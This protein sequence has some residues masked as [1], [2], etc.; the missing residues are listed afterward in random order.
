[1][2]VLREL[3]LYEVLSKSTVLYPRLWWSFAND[4]GKLIALA[5]GDGMK[6][7]N[8]DSEKVERDT[9]RQTA[10]AQSSSG[11]EDVVKELDVVCPFRVRARDSFAHLALRPA[12][13]KVG[14]G[15][16]SEATHVVT[17]QCNGFDLVSRCH[18]EPH[19]GSHQQ[20]VAG[21]DDENADTGHT[22]HFNQCFMRTRAVM[23]A[24]IHN[25]P[26]ERTVCIRQRLGVLV[27]P[28]KAFVCR[29]LISVTVRREVTDNRISNPAGSQHLRV[30][31]ATADDENRA[32]KSCQ[33]FL[34]EHNRPFL[35]ILA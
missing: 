2:P 18:A 10:H 26:I 15:T 30:V 34:V 19:G 27:A 5:F 17:V 9:F 13:D 25:A 12:I 32:L 3:H 7:L 11:Q 29:A 28:L 6:A 31:G 35:A 23:E 20:R 24:R 16:V 8:A 21:F 4:K 33:C 22:Q 1:M 14:H